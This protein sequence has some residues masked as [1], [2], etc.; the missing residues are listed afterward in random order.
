MFYWYASPLGNAVMRLNHAHWDEYFRICSFVLPQI[1]QQ[2]Q[3]QRKHR[4]EDGQRLNY[5][6]WHNMSVKI[7][8]KLLNIR[9]LYYIYGTYSFYI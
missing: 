6:G 8:T 9:D 3:Q 5:F 2:Q 7:P 1:F 4:N